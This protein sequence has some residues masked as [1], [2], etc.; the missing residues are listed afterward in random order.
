MLHDESADL[1]VMPRFKNPANREK[2]E[3]SNKKREEDSSTREKTKEEKIRD[4]ELDEFVLSTMLEQ[5]SSDED[6]V[7]L[8]KAEISNWKGSTFRS[9]FMKL[10][11]EVDCSMCGGTHNSPQLAAKIT[12]SPPKLSMHCRKLKDWTTIVEEI[13]ESM[14]TAL[15]SDVPFGIR[16]DATKIREHYQSMTYPKG[17]VPD[18]QVYK[19]SKMRE[20]P[21]WDPLSN[22]QLVR[23]Y[24][25]NM[26]GQKTTAIKKDLKYARED[27][28]KFVRQSG[29]MKL[30]N[31]VKILAVGP[32]ILN[33][34]K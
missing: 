12:G 1:V 13:P 16:L 17:V 26:G 20:L 29:V 3:K 28:S 9:Y 30:V 32:N 15:K 34:D 8:F 2:I 11:S 22:M 10:D 24:D 19:D 4:K 21:R 14:Y 18:I 23:A 31:P 7:N 5:V 33:C 25:A 6:N 27:T